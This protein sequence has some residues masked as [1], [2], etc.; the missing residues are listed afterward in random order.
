MVFSVIT[1]CFL[2]IMRVDLQLCNSCQNKTFEQIKQFRIKYIIA[3]KNLTVVAF[4]GA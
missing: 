3:D 4:K 1:F 2:S